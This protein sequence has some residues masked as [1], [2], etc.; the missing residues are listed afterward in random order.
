MAGAK[1]PS[2]AGWHAVRV[3]EVG[4][5]EDQREPQPSRDAQCAI[6]LPKWSTGEYALY[7]G[8]R[9]VEI[10]CYIFSCLLVVPGRPGR[11]LAASHGR[12]HSPCCAFF[13]CCAIDV[14]PRQV[15]RRQADALAQCGHRRMSFL[16]DYSTGSAVASLAQYWRFP[17]RRTSF[18]HPSVRLRAHRCSR[19][20]RAR[21]ASYR[22]TAARGGGARGTAR[23]CPGNAPRRAKARG[24]AEPAR[25]RVDHLDAVRAQHGCRKVVEGARARCAHPCPLPRRKRGR[26]DGRHGEPQDPGR[27]GAAPESVAETADEAA[28]R[29]V[30]CGGRVRQVVARRVLHVP[31]A[32]AE[33]EHVGPPRCRAQLGEPRPVVGRLP[34]ERLEAEAQPEAAAPPPAAAAAAAVVPAVAAKGRADARKARVVVAALAR[35]PRRTQPTAPVGASPTSPRP[36]RPR[37]TL[38][39]GSDRVDWRETAWSWCRGEGVRR[40]RKRHTSTAA[41]AGAAGRASTP[42]SP[43]ALWPGWTAGGT[44]SSVLRF[45]SDATSKKSARASESPYTATHKSPSVNS[46]AHRRSVVASWSGREGSGRLHGAAQAY[47]QRAAARPADPHRGDGMEASSPGAYRAPTAYRSAAATTSKVAAAPLAA[48]H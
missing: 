29:R 46:A 8:I 45:T 22:S 14:S 43:L 33:D 26:R 25:K 1:G 7:V 47:E 16:R 9:V 24:G 12:R 13:Q 39:A 34:S 35:R 28:Q 6:R 32:E 40:A 30:E 15:R 11:L 41:S 18:T 19:S 27:R 20:N 23:A 10:L 36:A 4:A 37:P 38:S 5:R 2:T 17:C 3:Q 42:L 31:D 21:A 44:S 48:H